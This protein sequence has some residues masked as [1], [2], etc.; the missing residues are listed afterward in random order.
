MVQGRNEHTG[1]SFTENSRLS[2][3]HRFISLHYQLVRRIL[4]AKLLAE[5]ESVAAAPPACICPKRSSATSDI[6]YRK[7]TWAKRDAR[8]GPPMATDWCEALQVTLW[9]TF[10]YGISA[11]AFTA[12]L[13]LDQ[14]TKG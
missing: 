10:S 9:W 3:A 8:P 2:T 1:N 4:D 12:L 5:K 11:T 14:I 6:R 7:S 13:V